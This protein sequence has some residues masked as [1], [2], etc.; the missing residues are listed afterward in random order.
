MV[1]IFALKKSRSFSA[2]FSLKLFS[3]DAWFFFQNLESF[4]KK[5]LRA[6]EEIETVAKIRKSCTIK[7][8]H[9]I[10]K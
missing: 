7:E 1:L 4:F 3:A 5:Q 9:P 8:T 6:S 10:P 2:Q